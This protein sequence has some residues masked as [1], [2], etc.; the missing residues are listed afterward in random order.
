MTLCIEK[1]VCLDRRYY[2][3]RANVDKKLY[4]FDL[5]GVSWFSGKFYRSDEVKAVGK[6]SGKVSRQAQ[7]W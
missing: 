1:I 5:F 6:R 3:N 7:L 4:L 2:M